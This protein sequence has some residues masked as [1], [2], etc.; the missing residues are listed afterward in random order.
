MPAAPQAATPATPSYT[1]AIMPIMPTGEIKRRWQPLV[2]AL[3][4]ASGLNV[5]LRY[6]DGS[7]RFQAAT[8]AGEPDLI[9]TGPLHVWHLRDRYLPLLRSNAPMT[10][11]IVVPKTGPLKDISD[12]RGRRV[13]VPEG[14]DLLS[15]DTVLKWLSL[16]HVQFIRQRTHTVSNGFWDIRMGKADAAV[17]NS[18]SLH[19]MEPEISNN[20][21]V[22]YQTEPL[23]PPALVVR[24]NLP[25]D[26]VKRLHDAL[27][28]LNDSK[29]VVMNNALMSDLT[30][31]D[32]DRDYGVLAKTPTAEAASHGP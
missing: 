27:L 21:R 20:L 10:G 31:A 30:E 16:Q 13:A 28:K 17:V 9:L 11:M 5:E 4:Q 7:D 23:P 18:V 2:T 32:L 29:P 1:L 26:I 25:P 14:A 15:R 12:L 3:S 24:R 19:L 6:Y 8:A 22:L